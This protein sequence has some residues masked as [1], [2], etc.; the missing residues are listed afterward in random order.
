[1]RDG[2]SR[3]EETIGKEF[4]DYG[5]RYKKQTI[6]GDK[7]ILEFESVGSGLMTAKPGQLDAFAISGADR[8]WHWTDAEIV[9]DTVVLSCSEVPEPAAA[10]Y[11]WAM[12]PSQRNL[13][14]NKEGIPAS[15]FRTDDWPL[16]DPDAEIVTVEKPAKPDGYESRDWE[17]PK[18]TQ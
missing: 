12:N 18:M 11:A 9:G 16:F 4:V 17:R 3:H 10:R 15:P 14:Y 5:P 8:V 6:R 13:L 1:V 2:P 7:I